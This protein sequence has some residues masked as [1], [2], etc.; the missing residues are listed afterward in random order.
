MKR[1]LPAGAKTILNR[2]HDAGY[3]AYLVGGCVRDALL[4]RE[5]HD[6][7]ICTSA[8]PEET[9]SLFAQCKVIKTGIQHGTVLLM[10]ED[11]GYEV[12]T[13]RADGAYAD[14]RHPVGVT[15][16]RSLREDLARRD[17]TI[18]AMAWSEE[19][20]YVDCFGG[21]DDL[22]RCLI[23][24]V[25]EPERR[26]DE[27]GLRILR[28][29]RFAARFGWQLEPE[30]EKALR[31]QAHLLKNISGERILTEL[32]G[33]LTSPAAEAILRD[34]REVFAVILPEIAP[35]FGHPQ[36]N[37][38]HC[39]DVWEHTLH[40]VGNVR[41]EFLLRF[42]MLLH[43]A[44]KPACFTRDEEGVGHFRGHPVV[45]ARLAGDVM[46]RLHCDNRFRE[47]VTLLIQ[48]HD[49]VRI[50]TRK[51]LRRMLGALGAERSRLLFQIMKADAGAQSYET[52][53]EK[54]DGLAAGE[55]LLE[56][57]IQE[58]ACCTVKDLAVNGRDLMA[59]G[60]KPGKRIGEILSAL[61]EAVIEEEVENEREA[62][63]E[64]YRS[65]HNS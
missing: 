27:D 15:F 19:T 54:L 36:Y 62:L 12:T 6:W 37:F 7:D 31:E 3:E 65:I 42:I 56:V 10:M 8:F 34:Y 64:R 48:W 53:E 46:E 38:H 22:H 35:M 1:W 18:N 39:Y 5:P 30:T 51:S 4:G 60:E 40:A 24:C 63:L 61:L 13:Y 59:A 20:G 33:I 43:D 2:F 14:H 29:L 49:K 11:G 52:R 21:L 26:F 57:L 23:R 55:A 25:G 9:L 17:F 58:N 32:Q 50:F 47:D 41:P 45:S 28:A 44:G 16:V